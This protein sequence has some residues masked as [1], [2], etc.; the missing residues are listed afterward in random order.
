MERLSR[1][2]NQSPEAVSQ[3]G[4]LASPAH[5]DDAL[6]IVGKNGAGKPTFLTPSFSQLSGTLNLRDIRVEELRHWKGLC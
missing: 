5:D 4:R 6:G 3:L 1:L 2:I